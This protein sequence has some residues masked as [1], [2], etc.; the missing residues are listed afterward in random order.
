MDDLDA[1]ATSAELLRRLRAGDRRFGPS[2][3][4]TVSGS[5]PD[6]NAATQPRQVP[7]RIVGV[8]SRPPGYA[9]PPG[10]KLPSIEPETPQGQNGPTLREAIIQAIKGLPADVA[11]NVT[12]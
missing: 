12:G 11:R 1:G 6:Q 5:T 7:G 2:M 9:P 10:I 3:N 8:A 4:F